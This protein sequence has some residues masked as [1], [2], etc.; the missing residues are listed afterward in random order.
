M[1]NENA[2]VY[3]LKSKHDQ[4][5]KIGKSINL[6][7]RLS[8]LQKDYEFDLE[9]SWTLEIP[10]KEVFKL[11]NLLH[12]SFEKARIDNLPKAKGYTEFFNISSL[13]DVLMFVDMISKYKSINISKGIHCFKNNS[14]SLKGEAWKKYLEVRKNQRILESQKIL[15]RFF[16]FIE[17]A[18]QRQIISF[19]REKN[20]IKISFFSKEEKLHSKRFK[21]YNIK[22]EKNK[23]FIVFNPFSSYVFNSDTNYLI[24]SV[25]IAVLFENDI[26]QN[27][28]NVYKKYLERL[29]WN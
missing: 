27:Y 3:L 1:Q 10:Q 7:Q 13:D 17:V 21:K 11:E 4:M 5:F 29:P 18:F 23:G 15:E 28:A 8:A 24:Y 14:M 22:L 12:F 16:R 19:S 9:N 6:T 26:I 25:D 20:K 2:I